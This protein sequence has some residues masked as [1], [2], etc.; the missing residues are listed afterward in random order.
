MR[1]E[2]LREQL[3]LQEQTGRS[4]A[5]RTT[6]RLQAQIAEADRAI[7]LQVRALDE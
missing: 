1:L 3:D 7:A 2:L 5:Q 6:T 4:E